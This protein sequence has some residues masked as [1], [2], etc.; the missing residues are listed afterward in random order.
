M[1]EDPG[2]TPRLR[3]GSSRRSASKMALVYNKSSKSSARKYER[4]NNMEP[5]VGGVTH[6]TVINPGKPRQN[7]FQW[8]EGRGMGHR[9]VSPAYQGVGSAA[10][11]RQK[12]AD[13]FKSARLYSV[14]ERGTVLGKPIHPK[15]LVGN[16]GDDGMAYNIEAL[17]RAMQQNARSAGA[18]SPASKRKASD[19]RGTYVHPSKA[20]TRFGV[21]AYGNEGPAER[22]RQAALEAADRSPSGPRAKTSKQRMAAARAAV[23][24]SRRSAVPLEVEEVEVKIKER[25]RAPR[26]AKPKTSKPKA[27]AKT[28][29]PKAKAKAKTSK[30]KPTVKAK[31][32]TSKAKPK[33][34]AKAKKTSSKSKSMAKKTSKKSSK[35]SSRKV[36]FFGRRRRGQEASIVKLLRSGK[37]PAMSRVTRLF[38]H[39]PR[40]PLVMSG[41]FKQAPA[42]KRTS[43]KK[44]SK[45]AVKKNPKYVVMNRRRR[46][47]R[48]HSM[49]AN[50]RHSRR[51]SR[52][53]SMRA[54]RRHSRKSSRRHSRRLRPNV[55]AQRVSRAPKSGKL[56]ASGKLH[57]VIEYKHGRGGYP[58]LMSP[59]VLPHAAI[60][61]FKFGGAAQAL[62]SM[63]EGERRAWL[64]SRLMAP[65]RKKTSKK[66]SKKAV[67]KN[68]KYVVMNRRSSRKGRRRLRRNALAILGTPVVK[69]ILVP[70]VGVLSGVVIARVL[71]TAA[72]STEGVRN[73]LDRGVAADA[74]W[75]TRMATNA[76]GI[77]ATAAVLPMIKATDARS[78]MLKQVVG[79]SLAGMGASLAGMALARALP[80]QPWAQSLAGMGEYVNQPM[81]GLGTMYATAGIGEYV[82]QPMSGLGTMYAAAGI[83]EYVNQPMN[84][85]GTEYAT[86]GIGEYVNQPM[87]G[88]GTFYAAAGAD[89]LMDAMEAAAGFTEAAAGMGQ[90]VDLPVAYGEGEADASL[91]AMYNRNPVGFESTV[92]PTDIAESVSKT[93]PYDRKVKTSIVTPESRGY[94]SGLFSGTIFSGMSGL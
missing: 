80:G 94:E 5:N 75:K 62:H 82:N 89:G 67:K 61:R 76:V 83:G 42:I 12:N 68:P 23:K 40:F 30:S 52:R 44:T 19:S 71:A 51:S 73:L 54:N 86:A 21:M 22:A 14:D 57:Q 33:A 92:I 20:T 93:I 78:E 65:K 15:R 63:P 7:P 8:I 29:K 16:G 47:S 69:S 26:T 36:G 66:T 53:H 43:A 24:S 90:A 41:R 81:N 77:A 13:K 28:S 88:M 48:K 46:T 45:K 60:R 2:H 25:V 84:G 50:R 56:R 72:A 87:S 1:L 4:S 27:K 34:K 37:I 9:H 64:A 18:A 3:T 91:E 38:G 70:G 17:R 11:W 58:V 35:K 55:L 32:K 31:A 59:Q 74:A 85:L 6:M 49:R 39:G 79:Y 10:K